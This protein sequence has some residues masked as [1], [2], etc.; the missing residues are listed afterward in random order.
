MRKVNP[1]KD[2]NLITVTVLLFGA[3]VFM[4]TMEILSSAFTN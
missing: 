4:I 2:E 3:A 1:K